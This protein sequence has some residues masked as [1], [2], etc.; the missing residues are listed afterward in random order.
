MLPTPAA[1]S[2]WPKRSL[3]AT[4]AGLRA[5]AVD[6]P[7]GGFGVDYAGSPGAVSGPGAGAVNSAGRAAAQDRCGAS[8]RAPF[9]WLG[10][11]REVAEDPV[12]GQPGGRGQGARLFE[13]V[14]GAGH[15]GQAVLAA[16]LRL[17]SLVEVQ[18]HLIA[19][20]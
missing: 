4:V 11:G 9:H 20:A 15:H 6:A 8:A 14:G 2:P 18:Y 17:G 1:R 7:I 13:Q 12:P 19:P 5:D 3:P 16:Q 10:L